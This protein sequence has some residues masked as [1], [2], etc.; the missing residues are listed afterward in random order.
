MEAHGDAQSMEMEWKDYNKTQR[1][2][3]IPLEQVHKGLILSGHHCS[4][5]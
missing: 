5:S 4:E 3:R 1:M 2:R